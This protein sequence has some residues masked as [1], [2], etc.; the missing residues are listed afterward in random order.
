EHAG[1]GA[2]ET[3]GDRL[4]GVLDHRARGRAAEV[5]GGGE[6]EVTE[7]HRLLELER[8]HAEIIP[9][10]AGIQ[11]EAIEV[12]SLEAGVVER[13]AHRVDR[14]AE[15]A[16]AVDLPLRRDAETDDRGRPRE[17]MIRHAGGLRCR[18]V[19]GQARSRE[20][21]RLAVLEDG[22]SIRQ[23]ALTGEP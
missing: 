8:A 12:V 19:D 3:R 10:E 17:R 2:A 6:T 14:E 20:P 1:D 23:A 16:V 4:R 21:S 7:S 11:E 13:Q 5:H 15:R 18:G 22:E 9:G